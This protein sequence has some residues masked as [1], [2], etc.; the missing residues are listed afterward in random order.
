MTTSSSTSIPGSAHANIGL[1]ALTLVG[2]TVG[3]LRQ[4]SKPS[5]VAG[6]AVG[7]L[8]WASSYLIT[9]QETPY[10]GHVLATVT[11][12]LLTAGMYRRYTATRRMMPA[13]VVAGIGSIGMA[14]NFRKAMEWKP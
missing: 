10:Y 14:Y 13:G 2:G 4:G 9:T 11:S 1:G 6:V 3:Y 8:F 12:S 5:L 7:S